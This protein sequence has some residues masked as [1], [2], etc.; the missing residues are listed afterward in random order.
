MASMGLLVFIIIVG[1]LYL[2]DSD[3][4]GNRLL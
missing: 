3:S 4:G 2:R 1:A